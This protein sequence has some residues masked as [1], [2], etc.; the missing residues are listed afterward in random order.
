MTGPDDRASTPRRVLVTGGAGFIGSHVVEA[1][2]LAGHAPIVLDDLSSGRREDVP[3]GVPLRAAD[4]VTADLAGL[5]ARERIDAVIHLAAQISAPRSMSEPDRD[6]A[7]NV[8][9]LRR[10]LDA[11][12]CAAVRR[13]VFVSS[14]GAIYGETSGPATEAT[15]PAPL[16]Y[17]GVHKLTGEGYVRLSGLPYA[18][19][20]PA[21]VYGPRQR[22]DLEGGVIAVFLDRVRAGQSIVIYGDGEQTRDFI[23]APDLADSIVRALGR[24]TDGIW[25]IS[26][27]RATSINALLAT[28]LHVTGRQM[29]VEYAPVRPG[30]VRHSVLDPSAAVADDLWRPRAALVD[31]ITT[32]WSSTPGRP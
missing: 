3:V 4:I 15:V 28:I 19:L 27:G 13:F 2:L 26:S 6:L 32:L 18:I 12:R 29:R 25:N 14:G 8:V 9:G 5:L 20:R 30:D 23:W 22:G 16:S 1:L 31:G 17:Y 7:I 21:N 24:P 10:L 11:A